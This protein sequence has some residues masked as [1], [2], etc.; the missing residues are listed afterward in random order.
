MQAKLQARGGSLLNVNSCDFYQNIQVLSTFVDG[1]VC[2]LLLVN[3]IYL[4]C[5]QF[6][7]DLDVTGS[8]I[9]ENRD[10]LVTSTAGTISITRSTIYGNSNYI[11]TS[12]IFKPTINIIFEYNRILLLLYLSIIVWHT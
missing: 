12:H 6:D 11:M 3:I 1:S 9:H 7:W 4:Y 2:I 10:V 5:D 8:N